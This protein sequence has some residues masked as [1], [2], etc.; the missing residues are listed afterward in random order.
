MPRTLQLPY[1]QLALPPVCVACGAVSEGTFLL[2]RSF[3][4]GRQGVLASV[5]IPLCAAHLAQAREKSKGERAAERIGLWGGLLVGVAAACGLLA[6]WTVSRQGS[7]WFNIPLALILGAGFFL[8]IWLGDL[9]WLAPRLA[10]KRA[11]AVRESVRITRFWPQDDCVELCF[12]NDEVA[13]R[14]AQGIAR[15]RGEGY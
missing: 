2:E 10:S 3:A 13:D 14:I 15:Q 6:Y 7:L 11:K 8:I 1:S 9:L 5:K 12:V 4:Q